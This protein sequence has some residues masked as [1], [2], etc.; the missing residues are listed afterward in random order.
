MTDFLHQFGL[1]DVQFNLMMLL[2]YQ[3][4]PVDG[5]SQAELSRM[6]LVNR[7]NITGLIDRMEKG[8]LVVRT[9]DAEDRRYNIVKL[10]AHG[11]E[12]LEQVD[13]Q[14]GREIRQR[15]EWLSDQEQK[16]L[17]KLL[18]KIREQYADG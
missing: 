13:P 5:L 10:T 6:M 16:K 1:T 12:L 4:G 14:Y 11:K 15:M 18:E 7:A 2:K 17:I 8:G 9:A 3:S